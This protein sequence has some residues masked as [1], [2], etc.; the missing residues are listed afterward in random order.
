MST[1]TSWTV[2][3]RT[4]ACILRT[5]TAEFT[6]RAYA[7][8]DPSHVGHTALVLRYGR[9]TNGMV[10]RINS[11]CIT[12]EA[13]ADESCDCA[14]QLASTLALCVREGSGM[15]IYAPFDEGR[16]VG[17]FNKINSIALMQRTGLSSHQAFAALGLS[18]DAR[19]FGYVG[20]ILNA[21][22]VASVRI[23]GRNQA[24]IAAVRRAGVDISG[25][26]DADGTPQSIMLA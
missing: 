6:T 15:I 3:R 25:Y 22:A 20:P 4:D 19:D 23:V 24:K 12:S 2:T 13:F 1:H 7:L 9:I 18:E 5:P 16:G 10:L 17:L 8:R 26:L 11:A 14:S 21:E